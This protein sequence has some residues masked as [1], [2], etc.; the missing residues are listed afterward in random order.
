MGYSAWA[1]QAFRL[2]GLS[3][4]VEFVKLSGWALG[5]EALRAE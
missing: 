5:T 1:K 3:R 4:I 2:H